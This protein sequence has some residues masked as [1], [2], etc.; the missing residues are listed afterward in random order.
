MSRLC[1]VE[2]LPWHG[3]PAHAKQSSKTWAGCP[4]HGRNRLGRFAIPGIRQTILAAIAFFLICFPALLHADENVLR[5]AA[6]TDSNA[7]Y[8]FYSSKN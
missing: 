1:F 5:W 6:A 8:G 2:I 4:C 3:H 7:P